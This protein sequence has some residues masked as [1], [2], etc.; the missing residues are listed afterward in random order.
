VHARGVGPVPIA[1]DQFNLQKLV[2]AIKFM[3]EPEVT[4]PL[5]LGRNTQSIIDAIF[6]FWLILQI[7]N[8]CTAE[9]CVGRPD[10]ML[11]K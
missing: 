1:V 7:D 11:Q 4:Y 2:D 6:S 9:M 5:H 10:T 8:S 3:L